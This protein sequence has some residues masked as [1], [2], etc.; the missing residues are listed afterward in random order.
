MH[1][2]L[3]PFAG[4]GNIET[5]QGPTLERHHHHRRTQGRAC[6]HLRHRADRRGGLWRHHP[7]T[8]ASGAAIRRWRHF[9]CGVLGRG[10]FVCVLDRAVL[11]RADAG[12]AVRS[13]RA[14][15]GDPVVLPGVGCRLRVHGTGTVAGVAV[16]RADHLGDHFRQLHHRQCLHRRCVAAGRARERLRHDRCGVRAGLHRRSADRWRSGRHQPSPAVLVRRRAGAAEL[17]LRIV[18]VA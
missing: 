1:A 11:Q 3:L 14:Q 12:R 18:R 9:H 13:F 16:R 10:V 17:L 2:R 7:G 6:L 15:A 4:D 8:A 5:H